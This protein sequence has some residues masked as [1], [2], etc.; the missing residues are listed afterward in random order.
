ML[1]VV[2]MTKD[3]WTTEEVNHAK[4]GEADELNQ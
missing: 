4:T 3:D 1:R 2:T